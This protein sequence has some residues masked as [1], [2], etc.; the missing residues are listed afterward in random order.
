MTAPHARDAVV[1]PDCHSR[2]AKMRRQSV[3]VAAAQR[4]VGFPGRTKILFHPQMDLYAAALEPAAAT[5]RE[6]RRLCNLN[7]AQQISVESP[8]ALLT[9]SG[10]SK[11]HVIDCSERMIRHETRNLLATDNWPLAT[12][13][14]EFLPTR[15]PIRSAW[16][17]RSRRRL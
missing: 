2:S 9:T 5:L 11:L 7:H 14:N 17:S 8:G 13:F 4:R 1:S 15:A 6:F 3:I 10:Q 16:R 12:A